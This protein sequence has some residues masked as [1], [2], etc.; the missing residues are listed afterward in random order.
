MRKEGEC[1]KLKQW[2]WVG[3]V[4]YLEFFSRFDENVKEM[5]QV[6]IAKNISYK[7]GNKQNKSKSKN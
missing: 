1:Q 2:E 6:N 3:L 5:L 7:T 4:F